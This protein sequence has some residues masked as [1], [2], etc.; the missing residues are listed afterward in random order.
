[1]YASDCSLYFTRM[2]QYVSGML[3]VSVRSFGDSLGSNS[4]R[5]VDFQPFC[6]TLPK[7]LEI[8]PI[9]SSVYTYVVCYPYL[10]G[11]LVMIVTL[12]HQG[13]ANIYNQHSSRRSVYVRCKTVNTCAFY[14]LFVSS[15]IV[16]GGMTALNSL[17]SVVACIY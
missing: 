3:I 16:S 11:A 15:Y 6:P 5:F 17:C 2:Y 12:K 10:C 8:E 7:R 14:R 1:M 4:S 9:R 13:D